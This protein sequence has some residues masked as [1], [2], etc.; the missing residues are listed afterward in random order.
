MRKYSYSGGQSSGTQWSEI[1]PGITLRP[2][3]A[4]IL[5]VFVTDFHHRKTSFSS[6]YFTCQPWQFWT[7]WFILLILQ[8]RQRRHWRQWRLRLHHSHSHSQSPPPTAT[9]I[10]QPRPSIPMP[11]NP[12][13]HACIDIVHPYFVGGF[14]TADSFGME[15]HLSL[16]LVPMNEDLRIFQKMLDISRKIA[17]MYLVSTGSSITHCTAISASVP[18][19]TGNISEVTVPL[20]NG[21]TFGHHSLSA[22]VLMTAVANG[23]AVL[24]LPPQCRRTTKIS[25]SYP[26]VHPW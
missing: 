5:Q 23:A 13:T 26:L 3:I 11:T 14:S 17:Q 25:E 15:P 7:H 8:W 9:P 2:E 10:P 20:M 6:L 16:R 19:A 1:Y 24:K 21:H 4:S 12:S 18:K 22:S